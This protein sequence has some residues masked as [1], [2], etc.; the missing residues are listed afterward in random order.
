MFLSAEGAQKLVD[1]KPGEKMG[2]QARQAS[3]CGM[4]PVFPILFPPYAASK[5]DN[6]ASCIS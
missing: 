6:F 5:Q 1:A 2:Y 4:G 3:G